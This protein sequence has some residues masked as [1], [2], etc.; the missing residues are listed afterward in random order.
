MNQN[1]FVRHFNTT[2]NGIL[3]SVFS[4]EYIAGLVYLFLISYMTY[5]APRLP[6]SAVAVF[7]NGWFRFGLLAF[8]AWLY[9]KDPTAAILIAVGW[10]VTNTYLLKNAIDQVHQTGVLTDNYIRLVSGSS[11]KNDA[12]ISAEV[13]LMRSELQ[14]KQS[15]GA[16]AGPVPQAVLS[17]TGGSSSI[18]NASIDTIPSGTPANA[19][20]MM[21]VAH[22]MS[23]QPGGLLSGAKNSAP[24]AYLPSDVMSVAAAPK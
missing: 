17:S 13:S 9:T 7:S 1:D 12:Q 10:W 20:T 24:A 8:I 2:S 21:E 5:A 22:P 3:D 23:S 6:L 15:Q 14:A 19:Q 11:L 4:N 16:F 18:A